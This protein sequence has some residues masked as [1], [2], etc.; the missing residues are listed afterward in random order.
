MTSAPLEVKV[1]Y[2]ASAGRGKRSASVSRTGVARTRWLALGLII[3]LVAGGLC[4]GT[5]WHVDRYLIGPN[6]FLHSTIPGVDLELISKMLGPQKTAIKTT[7]KGLPKKRS[8]PAPKSADVKPKAG[9]PKVGKPATID[10]DTIQLW[11]AAYSWLA[12]ASLA[13]CALT[14]SSGS[15]VGRWRGESFRR[16]GSILTAGAVLGMGLAIYTIL[17]KYG[18]KFPTGHLRYGMAGL[19]AVFFCVGLA[20]AGRLQGLARLASASLALSAVGSVVGLFLWSRLGAVSPDH[21]TITFLLIVFL[22]HSSW[23]WVLWPLSS[24]LPR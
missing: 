19:G 22:I 6:L 23:A 10:A 11:G 4:Y 20:V 2:D 17:N 16:T 1:I 8:T 9:K 3:L 18:M 24:R 13:M 12:L 15:L 21:A 7:P 14:L 5:W